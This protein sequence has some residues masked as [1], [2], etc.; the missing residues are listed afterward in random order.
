MKTL[1]ITGFEPFGG[2]DV[3]PSWECAKAM[4]DQMAGV[5]IVKAQ[6][7]VVWA[8]MNGAMNA[9]ID[10]Y[11]PDAVLSLGQA[12]GYSALCVERV[13][14]NLRECN[15]PDNAGAIVWNKPIVP[16]GPD[17][18]FSTLPCHAMLDALTRADLPA[19]FSY[20]AGQYLCNN[21]LYAA[22]YRAKTDMPGMLAGFVHVPYM[23]GQSDAAFTMAF[24]DMV[25]GVLTCCEAICATLGG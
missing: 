20:S 24:D 5:C 16:G 9:L 11:R 22:L 4:P 17:G 2:Q 6:L 7:P 13:A 23:A 12:G 10:E 21:A 14:V 18:L 8:R 19:A 25:R 1:L 15:R 3:N